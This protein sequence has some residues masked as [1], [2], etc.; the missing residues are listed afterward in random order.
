[1]YKKLSLIAVVLW[2]ALIFYMSSQPATQSGK[3]SNQITKYSIKAFNKVE[4]NTKIKKQSLNSIIRKNAHFFIYLGLGVLTVNA[5]RRSGIVRYKSIALLICILYAISDEFHQA[6]V[7][8][9]GPAVRD[10]FIDS[11]GALVGILVYLARS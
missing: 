10:V 2:M 6:F 1:M 8:G 5:L 3:L 9:R 7:P 11:A 4:P